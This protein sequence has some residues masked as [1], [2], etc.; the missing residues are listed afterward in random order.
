M[1]EINASRREAREILTDLFTPVRIGTQDAFDDA[2][3]NAVDEVSDLE[4][5]TD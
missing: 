3:S 1:L 4:I 2:L 5:K